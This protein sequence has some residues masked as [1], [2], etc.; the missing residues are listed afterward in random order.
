MMTAV[1]I[2]I[3]LFLALWM[4]LILR[5]ENRGRMVL[6]PFLVFA[7]L[8]VVFSWNLWLL[9]QDEVVVRPYHVVVSMTATASFLTGYFFFLAYRK[10]LSGARG[11]AS[12]LERFLRQPLARSRSD[13]VY[14][15]ILVLL[16]I[17]GCGI[18]AVYYRDMPPTMQAARNLLTGGELESV[19][20]T[21][22][23]GRRELTKSYVFGGEYRGQGVLRSFMFTIWV[24]GLTLSMVLAFSRK[25]TLWKL[26]VL[27]FLAGVFYF[28]GGTGER[29]RLLWG[30][31]VGLIGLSYVLR[32]NM[33]RLLAAGVGLAA[34]LF[35][36]TLIMP[37]YKTDEPGK[38][39]PYQIAVSIV[40]RILQGNKINN[41]RVMNYLESGEMR[42]TYGE[43]HLLVAL[44]T[45]PGIHRPPLGHRLGELM[46][47]SKTTYYT[48]TYLGDVYLDFGLPG[49]VL[50]YLFLGML[51]CGVF[52]LALRIGKRVENIPF[53][54]F[55]VFRLGEMG[56][57]GGVTTLFT[58]LVPAL[59][60]HSMV[61]LF[62]G[63]QPV[64]GANRTA[65][66]LNDPLSHR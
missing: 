61:M 7:V 10:T 63:L 53:L 52:H 58:G 6:T 60:V 21:V 19:Q 22:S 45:L 64:S 34:V 51:L 23:S 13:H 27:L 35:L 18:G 15:L 20:S 3:H 39:I 38:Q 17:S 1:F 28:V 36:L 57:T 32:F 56:L 29:S 42:R 62:M 50:V 11:A 66:C 8:D 65:M 40:N 31:G 12:L 49:T 54:A 33:G 14:L 16:L 44:N 37:R 9:F 43:E 2:G 26:W 48:G 46:G 55:V 59:F 25:R 5:V 47:D 41:V 30:L 24:Y 4:I